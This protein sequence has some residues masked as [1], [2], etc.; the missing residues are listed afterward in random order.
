MGLLDKLTE[1]KFEND[2]LAAAKIAKT[3]AAEKAQDAQDKGK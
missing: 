3:I 2:Q 1:K